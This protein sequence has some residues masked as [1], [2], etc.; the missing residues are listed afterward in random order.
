[1]KMAL[2]MRKRKSLKSRMIA[3]VAVTRVAAMRTPKMRS[4]TII[5]DSQL[6][7]GS[8]DDDYRA[9]PPP[10]TIPNALRPVHLRDKDEPSQQRS[11]IAMTATIAMTAMI[12]TTKKKKGSASSLSQ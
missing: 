4:E 2:S 9:L 11:V 10:L 5:D 3:I 6:A 7:K 8:D 1:M 12:A